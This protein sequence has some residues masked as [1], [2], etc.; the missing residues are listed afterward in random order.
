[1]SYFRHIY[2]IQEGG[3]IENRN[4]YLTNL[5]HK[6][7]TYIYGKISSDSSQIG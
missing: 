2:F 7:I 6:K 3:I 5:T 4:E 1:M